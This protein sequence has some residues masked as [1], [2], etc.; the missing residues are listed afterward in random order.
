MQR[1]IDD[2][3]RLR[4][5][6]ASFFCEDPHSFKLEDCLK[7]F[8][9]FCT[10]FNKAIDENNE[11]KIQEEKVEMR[12]KLKQQQQLKSKKKTT[13]HQI[14]VCFSLKNKLKGLK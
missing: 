4:L 7:I 10:R 14:N 2:M 3:E 8:Q 11:R 1:K 12:K 9:H 5:D 13:R 6:L